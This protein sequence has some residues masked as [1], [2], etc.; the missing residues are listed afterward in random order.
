MCPPN[1]AKITSVVYVNQWGNLA[2][3]R[4]LQYLLYENVI[5]KVIWPANAASITS[6]VYVNQ[7]GNWVRGFGP[8]FIEGGCKNQEGEQET[9]VSCND[10]VIESAKMANNRHYFIN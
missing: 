6:V 5:E 2:R 1:A 9:G 10:G 3:K 7:G 8:F 4:G